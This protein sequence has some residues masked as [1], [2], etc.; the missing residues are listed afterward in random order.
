M[1]SLIIISI[2]FMSF[3]IQALEEGVYT[4]IVKKQQQKKQSRWTLA[5][6]LALKKEMALQD[7]W[8]AMNSSSNI[9]ELYIGGDHSS[10]RRST[11]AAP[12]SYNRF[13]F[14][15]GHLGVYVYSFGLETQQ[16]TSNE[17]TGIE[18]KET[19]LMFHW[20]ILGTST[21]T[22][23]IT[24]TYG[25]RELEHSSYG[26]YKNSFGQA[27]MTL[28]LFDFLGVEGMYRKYNDDQNDALT[29]TLEGTR[30]ELTAF[31]DISFIRLYTK[32]WEETMK[33]STG[34]SEVYRKGIS[35]G[36]RLYF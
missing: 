9:F 24:L 25:S 27:S 26:N 20:R 14:D 19:S 4:V 28:Y 2:L 34:T 33:F 21:Q 15:S 16:Q 6:W 1:K 35:L 13:K 17:V 12:N 30:E 5:S 3:S 22:T 7:Q 32:W 11:I 29:N 8:L 23:N 36:G 18:H 31:I 10:Y